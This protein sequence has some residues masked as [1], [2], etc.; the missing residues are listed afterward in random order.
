MSK[1]PV[2]VAMSGGVD[3]AVAAY[4]A[5]QQGYEVTGI[6][7]RLDNTPEDDTLDK[8]CEAL[9]IRLIRWDCRKSFH[10]R[11]IHPAAE[12]YASGRTPNPCCECN[13]VLK[14][15]ELLRAADVNGMAKVFT[16]HYVSLAQDESG[17]FI[18]RCGRDRR[19]DQSYFLFRLTQHELARTGFPL[20]GM[21]KSEVR[22]IADRAGLP[23]ASRPDS[24]DACFQIPGEC[25]GETLRRRSGLPIRYGRF[26]Y[27]NKCVGKHQGIHRYTIGQRQGLNVALGVPGYISRIDA[28]SGNIILTTEQRDLM[29]MAFTVARENWIS[30]MKPEFD[31]GLTVR[32]RYRSPGVACRIE[33]LD[34]NRLLVIPAEPLRAVT[35]GQAA[36][37]YSGDVML[38]GGEIESV[39][40]DV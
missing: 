20:G 38:G 33:V 32:V 30:G 2:A 18:L 15:A 17:R 9:G 3:S 34:E 27:Q 35:P 5:I 4:L 29:S 6:N 25:C 11:V 19:K 13:K 36:V 37:F 21:E 28:E 31:T 10:D 14:F 24:Q 23:C 8:C 22:Q 7:L 12:V 40:D 26:I 16:G 39:H 1:I